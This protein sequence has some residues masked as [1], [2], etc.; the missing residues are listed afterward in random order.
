M[1]IADEQYVSLVTYTK[2]GTPKPLPVWIVDL[3]TNDDGQ[4]IAGFTT[5]KDSWKA[6]RIRNT[7]RVTL[8]PCDQR[9]NVT[10]GSEIVEGSATITQGAEFPLVQGLIKDKY[11]IW[12]SV[13]KAM[14]SMRALLKKGGQSDSA[15]LITLNS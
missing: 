4:R 15:V 6:K 9:G 3:G 12:V 11:G 1:S 2:D 7:P 14:N 8:Q 13:I 10:E 5:W